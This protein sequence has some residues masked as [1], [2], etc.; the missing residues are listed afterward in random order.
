M[1]HGT[2]SSPHRGWRFY[3]IPVTFVLAW[4]AL[5]ICFGYVG[6]GREVAKASD[7]LYLSLQLFVLH[8]SDFPEHM[9]WQLEVARFLAPAGELIGLIL[10][11]MGIATLWGDPLRLALL[12]FSPR[13]HVVICGIGRKGLQLVR[14]F[15]HDGRTVLVVDKEITNPLIAVCDQL[16]AIVLIG[17]ATKVEILRK[18]RLHRAESLIATC[19]EDGANVEVAVRADEVLARR[20][21]A[22]ADLKCYV[23]VVDLELRTLFRQHKILATRRKA[24]QVEMFN[25]FENSA[26]VLFRRHFLDHGVPIT[27]KNDSR[28]PHLVV[29]GFGQLGESVVLQAVRSAQYPNGKKLRTTVI[30]KDA[31]RKHERFLVRYGAFHELSDATFIQGEAESPALFRRVKEWCADND[32]IVTLVVGFDNDSHSLSLALSLMDISQQFGC[33]ILVRTASDGGLAKLM[34]DVKE[35]SPEM[36]QVYGFGRIEEACSAKVVVD[37]SLNRF[38][39]MIHSSFVDKRKREGRNPDDPSMK[40]WQDLDPDL[41]DSNW[42]QAEH[43]PFKVRAINCET[44]SLQET[45]GVRQ[46]GDTRL[47]SLG[48]EDAAKLARMEHHR[49]F[50]ER[51]LAGWKRGSAKDMN[52]RVH[53]DLKPWEELTETVRQYDVEAVKLIPQLLALD[54]RMMYRKGGKPRPKS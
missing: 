40:S 21:R 48:D 29:F 51:S 7:R 3:T 32:F 47:E 41:R 20:E 24:L 11:A 1:T 38:A 53:P 17:D 39:T 10:G 23:H 12:R 36:S 42:Q 18:A 6:Y 13:R 30:D 43:I 33:P 35:Q 34:A 2:R 44:A 27:D 4:I 22:T 5:V 9:S 16:G 50:A 49:W 14:D 19:G 26:R 28:Q 15:R 46:M 8:G 54:R 37:D 52:K 31:R 25:I 45:S